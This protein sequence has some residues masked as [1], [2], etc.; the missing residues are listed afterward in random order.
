MHYYFIMIRSLQCKAGSCVA[1]FYFLVVRDI[2]S[3]GIGKYTGLCC[4][5]EMKCYV[6]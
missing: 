2:N 3:G 6:E 5:A 4:H 1:V